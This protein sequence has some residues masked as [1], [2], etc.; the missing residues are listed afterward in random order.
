MTNNLDDFEQP[1]L[2]PEQPVRSN[3]GSNLTGAW[4]SPLFKLFVLMVV[5]AAVVAVSVSFFSSGNTHSTAG[6]VKPPELNEAPGGKTSPYMKQQTELAN[7]NAVQE[8]IKTGGS[9]LPTPIG[10]THET[11]ALDNNAKN[12]QLNELHAEIDKM[13]K[14]LQQVKNPQV[15]QQA[16]QQQ[17]Q[18]Q[19]FDDS[20][21][22]AMQH[23]MTQLMDSWTLKGGTKEVM[24]T[25]IDEKKEA[26]AKEALAAAQASNRPV[27]KTIIPAGTVSY[28]QLLTEANSDVPGPIMAQIVSGPFAGSRAVGSFQVAN[29]NADYLVLQ[30]NLV[31]FKNKDYP[32]SAVALDPDTTLGGMAT[33]VNQ[34]YFTRVILPAAAG[35][36]QGFG[37][38][39]G[40]G[41]SSVETNGTTTIVQQSGHGVTQ[42]A[43]QGLGQASQTASQFF[44][45]QANVTRPLVRVAAGTPIGLFFTSTVTDQQPQQ[46]ELMNTQQGQNGYSNNGYNQSYPQQGQNGYSNVTNAGYN[47]QTQGYNNNPQNL[48]YPNA[49]TSNIYG[50]SNN[51]TTAYGTSGT[52][53]T[54]YYPGMS[55]PAAG[56]TTPST[57]G[58]TVIY[59]H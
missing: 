6:L 48:P 33:E 29:G 23:Q 2:T 51:G 55:S 58:S 3:M 35:F 43:F 9:S 12:E 36:L 19:Q 44:Q 27:P 56:L 49:G 42:G 26:A 28:A 54:G 8:A 20:L 57:P 13:N 31:N 41:N 45:N 50:N 52:A 18:Q 14:Q 1:E 16:Q 10:Q 59:T 53:N 7:S 15:Q 47:G 30:F 40:Q 46:G 22:Q 34:R 37:S 5:V 17:V 4:S 24:V 38:A 21:A 32:I 39:L 11:S 25:K